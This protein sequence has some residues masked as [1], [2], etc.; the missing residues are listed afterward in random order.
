MMDG[1]AGMG[2]WMMLWGLIGLAVLVLAVLGIVWL[3]RNPTI[4]RRDDERS[5]PAEQ[6]LRRRYAAG[7][8]DREEYQQR[9]TD[10]R[11]DRRGT[12]Q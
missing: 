11:A 9:L 3:V 5:D 7:Q 8:I 1:M 2:L 4:A 6:E 12:Q 10:L